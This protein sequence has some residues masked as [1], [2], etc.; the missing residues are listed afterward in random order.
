LI[1]L[2]IKSAFCTVCTVAKFVLEVFVS[3]N[4]AY[5]KYIEHKATHFCIVV[6]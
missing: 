2:I 3:A 1:T 4:L 6:F 5:V